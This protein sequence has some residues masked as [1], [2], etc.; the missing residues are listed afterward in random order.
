MKEIPTATL[1]KV[2]PKILAMFPDYRKKRV[3]LWSREQVSCNTEWSGGSRSHYR[4][5][6]LD[7]WGSTPVG[8]Q[9]TMFS[10]KSFDDVTTPLAPRHCIVQTGVTGGK[11]AQMYVHLHPSDFRLVVD[12]I[13]G[14][15][16]A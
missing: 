4:L 3:M 14:K 2:L 1:K 15:E 12:A 16:A 6:N 9:V 7:N 5:V 13:A 10:G 8:G 11:T